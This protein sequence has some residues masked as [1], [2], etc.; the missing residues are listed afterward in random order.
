MKQAI[1]VTHEPSM[2]PWARSVRLALHLTQQ[3]LAD[4]CGISQEEVDL[5]E[6]HLPVKLDA[7]RKLQKELWAARNALCHTFPR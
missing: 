2:K 4:R 1:T 7:K 5:F 3:E 6:H